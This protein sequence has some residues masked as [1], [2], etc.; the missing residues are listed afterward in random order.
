MVATIP[1]TIVPPSPHRRNSHS[2]DKACPGDGA[3]RNAGCW[4]HVKS[5]QFW[6]FFFVAS[7]R[8]KSYPKITQMSNTWV[9]SLYIY[10]YTVYIYIYKYTVYTRI[11]I[12][13][14]IHVY[15]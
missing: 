13:I 5:P 6:C 12:Y 9:Q 14:H 3:T 15:L 11:Y 10:I 8:L 7:I 1:T 4:S 2:W